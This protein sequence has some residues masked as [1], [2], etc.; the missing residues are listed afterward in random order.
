MSGMSFHPPPLDLMLV[1]QRFEALP[2]VDVLHRL[3]VRRAPAAPLPIVY[4]DADSLLHIERI[5]KQPH[6]TAAGQCSKAFD[7]CGE[8]HAIVGRR[9]L[10]AMQLLNVSSEPEQYTPA[11]RPR[12]ALACAVGKNF[13]H[14]RCIGHLVFLSRS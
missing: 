5:G 7:D 9:R 11:P 12:I 2:Q 8:L 4:P 1:R 14:L 13:Y 6:M 3:L 10:A